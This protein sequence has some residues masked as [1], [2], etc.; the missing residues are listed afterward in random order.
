MA[1]INL[2]PWR[3][4]LRNQRKKEFFTM[5]GGAVVLMLAIV[6]YAH[7][8]IIG[9]AEYQQQRNQFLSAEITKVKARNREIDEL[10][11]RKEQLIARMDVIKDLQGNRP[12][13]V[14]LFEELVKAVPEGL[15]LIKVE[16]QGRVL[17][18]VGGA[19]SNARVSTFMRKLD[20]SEWFAEPSL[21]VIEAKTT[22]VERSRTFT[23]R[24]RQLSVEEGADG[25]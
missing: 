9:M 6:G 22:G 18:I 17:T 1:H 12:E 14:H 19:Q 10:E 16:Q 15:H 20:E 4:E 24:V 5:M 21:D 2:L 7:M 23:L 3:E 25:S 13:V 8:H 11:K